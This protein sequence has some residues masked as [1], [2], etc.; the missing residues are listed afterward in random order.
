MHLP[1]THPQPLRVSCCSFSFF[2]HVVFLSRFLSSAGKEEVRSL[3]SKGEVDQFNGHDAPWGHN[4]T[5]TSK[6]INLT[7]PL[8]YRANYEPRY[9]P[10]V[11]LS[12]QLAPWADERFVGYG[13]NKIAYIN[14][15]HGLN[16]TFH[17]HPYG[18]AV[19]V[20]HPRTHA[21]N[22]FVAQKHRGE[23]AMELLR[24]KIE[25]EV[26]SGMYVPVIRNCQERPQEEDDEQRETTSDDVQDSSQEGDEAGG[27]QGKEQLPDANTEEDGKGKPT[28]NT[29][30]KE[31]SQDPSTESGKKKNSSGSNGK[32]TKS[33]GSK[34]TSGESKKGGGKGGKQGKGAARLHRKH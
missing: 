25:M 32:G 13:G 27:E 30:E 31:G 22:V 19:H 16:F 20:P 18:Y 11:L 1:P 7:R 4:P 34:A 17:V 9:E 23:S 28:E 3:Y 26:E 12:R 6:W 21:S 24:A 10:F 29:N 14:Q 33:D 2:H 15:L 8:L 5:N